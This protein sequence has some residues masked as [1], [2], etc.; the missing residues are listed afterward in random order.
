MH[1]M[2]NNTVLQMQHME[3]VSLDRNKWPSLKVTNDNV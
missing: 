3:H 2:N 1:L